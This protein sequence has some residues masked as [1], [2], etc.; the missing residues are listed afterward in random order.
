MPRGMAVRFHY[1]ERKHTDIVAHSTDGFPTHT[2]AEFLGLLG[3][4]ATSGPDVA[5]P[6]PVEQ[7]LG[8]HRR[9]WRLLQAPKPFPVSFA[10][11]KYFGV[12]SAAFISA[13]GEEQ[14][15]RYRI[16]PDAGEQYLDDE[17]LK[18][19]GPNYEFEEVKERGGG[20]GHQVSGDGATGC[21]GG[22]GG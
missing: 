20:W 12:T 4:I 7:F 14:F 11:E 15:F 3:A 13:S 21:S 19:K 5:H 10:T 9:R 1:G 18:A 22:C 16:L 2:G 8:S 17:A 6:T